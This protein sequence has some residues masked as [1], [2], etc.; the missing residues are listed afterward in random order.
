MLA[1]RCFRLLFAVVASAPGGEAD[2]RKPEAVLDAHRDNV[3]WLTL[4][5]PGKRLLS[6]SA[7]NT[8][9]VW[10]RATRQ[11]LLT[12]DLKSPVYAGAF[13]PDGRILATCSGDSRVALW[14]A[15][16]GAPIRSLDGHRAPVYSVAFSAD[17][18]YL[19]SGSGE[20][21]NDC[22]LWDVRTGR[23]LARGRGHQRPIYGV[24]FSG[25]ELATSSSDKSL[26]LWNLP[27][28]DKSRTLAGHTSDVY[29]C[30]FCPG[31]DLLASVSQDKS[32]RIWDV[33]SGN[34]RFTLTGHRDPVYGMAFSADGN[35]LAT[36][37]DDRAIHFWDV[38]A[39]KSLEV[40]KQ[41][42]GEAIFALAFA[43]DG[44]LFSAGAEGKIHI[45]KLRRPSF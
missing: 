10:D 32:V 41:A 28:L 24:A 31:G 5:A 42:H 9:R 38:R 11:L 26:R 37:G 29:R 45:W 43:P 33:T 3:Y 16:T 34:L 7:D 2:S 39:G 13:S 19:A 27:G 40:W 35:L 12:L 14:N 18:R 23:L 17:G 44:T 25:S 36:A 6:T 22:I 8:A 20:P 21:E 1:L 15:G 30:G 4:D